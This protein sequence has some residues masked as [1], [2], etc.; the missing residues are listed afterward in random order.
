MAKQLKHISQTE[1]TSATPIGILSTDQRDNWA[2]AYLEL[3]K[4]EVNCKNMKLIQS[5]LFTVSLDQCVPFEEKDKYNILSQQ[6]IHGGGSAQN[7][8]NRWMDKTIQVS[9]TYSLLLSI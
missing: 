3:S 7:S 4:C 5:S 9:Y 2:Q 1:T 8:A 6:L